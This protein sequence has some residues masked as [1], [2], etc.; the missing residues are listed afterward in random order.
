MKSEE[1]W[2]MV[3]EEGRDALVATIRPSG[4]PHCVPVWYAV[5]AEKIYFS[6]SI[7]SVKVRNLRYNPRV[8][9]TI[10]QP[11]NPTAFV[12][13]EGVAD[14]V[15]GTPNDKIRL[16]KQIYARYGESFSGQ[17]DLEETVIV[18]VTVTRMIGENYG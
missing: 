14:F 8:A 17:V 3:A 5:K 11:N 16:L 4:Q 12:M 10:S 18:R 7:H 9:L 2:E 13:I 1:M 6:T 15:E